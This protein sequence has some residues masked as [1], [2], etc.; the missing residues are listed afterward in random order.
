MAG[1]CSV[2]GPTAGLAAL[3]FSIAASLGSVHAQAP[4][5]A[6]R[7]TESDVLFYCSF[8]DTIQ[9]EVQA[10]A[11]GATATGEVRFTR[12]LK[13]RALVT[14]HTLG[15]TFPRQGNLAALAGTVTFW[16]APIDWRIGDGCFHHFFRV[17]AQP[18]SDRPAAR[19]F[20]ILL[21]KFYEWDTVVAYGMSGELT[22]PNLLQVPMDKMWAPGKWHQV[23]FSWDGQGA[24]LYVD[25]ARQ[26]H[27]YLRAA[28]D[29]LTAECFRVGGPYFLA[30]QTLTA[31]DELTIYSRRL[32]EQE[33]ELRYRTELID[34]VMGS[35]L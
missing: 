32:S 26:Y 22:G 3:A 2:P 21:Y 5:P 6:P 28:P 17:E 35:H 9:P 8:N 1:A 23:A 4:P 19:V 15:A 12:G 33:V 18:L 30:N 11:R 7:P 27:R 29:L 16:V 20:D 10:G 31:V 24:A 25:G 13:G 34:G 14:G